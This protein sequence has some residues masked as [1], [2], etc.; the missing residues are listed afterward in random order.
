MAEVE[1]G[2]G[3]KRPPKVVKFR[4]KG[5]PRDDPTE[6]IPETK[7][8]TAADEWV[9]SNIVFRVLAKK[10]GIPVT[11]L[12]DRS[13]RENWDERKR[14]FLR[15]VEE[16]KAGLSDVPSAE[17]GRTESPPT[18]EDRREARVDEAAA[19]KKS[20]A[21]IVLH[22]ISYAMTG[23]LANAM[24][25]DIVSE[26][27]KPKTL[28]ELFR[29][30]K[31]VALF[32][33]MVVGDPEPPPK[34]LQVFEVEFQTRGGAINTIERLEGETLEDAMGRLDREHSE[35]KERLISSFI[36]PAGSTG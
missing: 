8:E 25:R 33:K 16:K 7:F 24:D 15:I 32:Y 20:Q 31:D 17:Q 22:E 3:T 27:E 19:D 5:A 23:A 1:D 12:F 18:T 6:P 9:Q 11:T 10:W 28:A 35:A 4:P 26:L 21:E 30:S 13:K 2:S 34:P 14:Q 36:Q 29:A